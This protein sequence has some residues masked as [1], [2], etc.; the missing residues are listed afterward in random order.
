[1]LRFANNPKEKKM[2]TQ[3]PK[4]SGKT[5]KNLSRKQKPVVQLS[6]NAFYLIALAL[7]L[8]KT[9]SPQLFKEYQVSPV[10]ICR[11]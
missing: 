6:D 11:N 3:H 9:I 4:S 1:M 8:K 5:K 2:K 10:H 7:E